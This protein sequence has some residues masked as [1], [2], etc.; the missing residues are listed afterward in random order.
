MI[1]KEIIL[2]TPNFSHL[3]ELSMKFSK[4]NTIMTDEMVFRFEKKT[5]FF[6]EQRGQYFNPKNN[7]YSG[8]ISDI[9]DVYFLR[10][11]QFDRSYFRRLYKDVNVRKFPENA[12]VIL[13]D[14]RSMFENDTLPETITIFT[15]NDK[16]YGFLHSKPRIVGE[17]E[18]R[19]TQLV[20]S[21]FPPNRK[22][23]EITNFLISNTV[24]YT[25]KKIGNP[26]DYF[27]NIQ[28]SGKPFLHIQDFFNS[29]DS[30]ARSDNM[31]YSDFLA[32]AEQLSSND[33]AIRNCGIETLIQYNPKK[34]LALQ[35]FLIFMTSVK[36]EDDFNNSAK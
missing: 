21:H 6:R 27:I 23:C 13:Y 18:W 12:D 8:Q 35:S 33:P 2:L 7:A 22:E 15:F 34:Y 3:H 1:N 26:I 16:T 5:V 28:K 31:T 17:M 19:R 25:H 10:G 9:K 11:A 20:N 14:E 29:R 36:E 30:S 24:L 32:M 4:Q